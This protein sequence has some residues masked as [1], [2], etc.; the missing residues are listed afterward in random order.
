M[1]GWEVGKSEI[2]ASLHQLEGLST[3]AIFLGHGT[4]EALLGPPSA[5]DELSTEV[6]YS[7]IYDRTLI[8]RGPRQLFA[9]C[10]LAGR[11]LGAEV[12]AI[13][14]RSFLGYTDNISIDAVTPNCSRMWLHILQEVV[15]EIVKTRSIDQSHRQLL[16]K[17]Y[18]EAFWYYQEGEGKDDDERILM[19]SYL[20]EQQNGLCCYESS[21]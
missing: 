21:D 11:I 7:V 19:Q 1:P 5:S 16:T 18:E 17:L 6:H 4:A 12:A 13:S 10:C 20:V 14:S 2:E 9:F 8:S 3:I 15:N